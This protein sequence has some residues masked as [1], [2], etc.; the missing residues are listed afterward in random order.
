MATYGGGDVD[1]L[2]ALGV[3]PV[4]VPDIDPR[5]K[6]AGGVA[7]W[8]R[9]RVR[10]KAPVVA[11]NEALEF[12]KVAAARPDL[13]TAVEYD[14]KRPDYR[15]LSELAPTVPPPKG[16][17]PYTVP[18]DT[19]AVQVGAA[20]GRRADAETLVE[21][22]RDRIAAA[23]KANPEFAG[24]RAV[25]IDPDDDGGVYV[26]AQNDVRTRF[27]G[28]LGFTMPAQIERLF[29]GQFYAQISAERLDLL[30]TAD[31][32]VLVASRKPQT[33]GL[34]TSRSFKGLRAVREERLAR[35]DEPDLAIAMS[36][37]SVLSTPYQLREVVPRLRAALA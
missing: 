10:G 6:R 20:L 21:A 34:T 37:S 26:F 12:E 29:K 30:D 3:T 11:S 4:L 24:S 18:W 1:T 19:M 14:L 32:L 25:L 33:K 36:Y 31:V 23:A 22:T 28:D 2:L 9:S 13:I 5:W 17:A 15:K 35:I 27:L 8:S 16:F 7:P